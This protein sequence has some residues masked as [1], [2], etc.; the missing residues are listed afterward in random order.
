MQNHIQARRNLR[1]ELGPPVLEM[2]WFG[3]FSF[4]LGL[5]QVKPL[6]AC[7]RT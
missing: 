5:K 6:T 1:T 2:N 3:V 7:K 4:E